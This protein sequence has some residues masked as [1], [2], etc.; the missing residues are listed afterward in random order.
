M[1]KDIERP[2]GKYQSHPDFLGIPIQD[3]NQP[4]AVDDRLL[5][6]A[7]RKGEIQEIEAL[8]AAGAQINLPGDLGNTPL[9]NAVL[10]GSKPAVLKLLELGAKANIKNEFGQTAADVARNGGHADLGAIISA[11]RECLVR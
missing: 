3:V 2:I 4:G 1:N 9:H 6:I 7:A 8:V 10:T 11:H 5:H